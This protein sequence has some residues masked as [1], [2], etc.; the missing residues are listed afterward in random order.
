MNIQ[1]VFRTEAV[2]SR[3]Q[4]LVEFKPLAYRMM[5][6]E[7][8]DPRDMVPLIARN[9]TKLFGPWSQGEEMT[10]DVDSLGSPYIDG[11]DPHSAGRLWVYPLN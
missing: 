7:K 3:M 8:Q 6:W 9:M 11:S 10:L 5:E 1:R 4:V 2:F